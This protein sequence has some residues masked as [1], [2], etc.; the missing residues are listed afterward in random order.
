MMQKIGMEFVYNPTKEMY[1]QNLAKASF[2]VTTSISDMLPNSMLEAIYVGAVPVAPRNLCFPEFI[3][4]D[5]LYTPYDLQ[6]IID[7]IVKKPVRQHDIM[8]YSKD[9]IIERYLNEMNI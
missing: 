5:N 4:P 6:E 8:K 3:H 2:V 9:I 1:H 7:I